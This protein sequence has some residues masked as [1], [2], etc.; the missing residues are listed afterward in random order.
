MMLASKQ[1]QESVASS[2]ELL[3]LL[4]LT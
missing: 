2:T 1:L 4:L 3:L